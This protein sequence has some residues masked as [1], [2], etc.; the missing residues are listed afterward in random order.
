MRVDGTTGA[1][2]RPSEEAGVRSRRPPHPYPR[3]SF[4]EDAWNHMVVKASSWARHSGHS[5]LD[6]RGNPGLA[7]MLVDW[8]QERGRRNGL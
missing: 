8:R 3:E 7:R 2:G 1:G 4:V 6:Q 5:G